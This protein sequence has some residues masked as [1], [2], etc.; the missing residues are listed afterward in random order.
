MGIDIFLQETFLT[1]DS[2][3]LL[4]YVDE[5]Y[6]SVGVGAVCPENGKGRPKGGLACLFKK[7]IQLDVDIILSN[8]DFMMTDITI[9][10]IKI[11][12]LNCYVRSNLG[13]PESHNQYL[14]NLYQMES[15]IEQHNNDNFITVGDF[16]ADPFYGRTWYDMKNF[17]DRNNLTC[18]DKELLPSD[19][20]TYIGFADSYCKWLDH[21]IGKI[22]EKIKFNY[23]KIA[24]D[25]I[26]S[27]H[28]PVIASIKID[29]NIKYNFKSSE[30][31]DKNLINWNTIPKLS[32]KKISEDAAKI[33]GTYRDWDVFKCSTDKCSSLK[34]F[35]S[36]VLMYE[37]MTK[38]VEYCSN[39]YKKKLINV[40]I[41][42]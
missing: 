9:S 15:M 23:I 12:F 8:D 29:T 27:D 42:N 26:G 24:H 38:P 39:D 41:L 21:I 16:N 28:F 13:D 10:D 20:F 31:D 25:C 19:S 30:N 6:Y 1:L 11:T 5:N 7:E 36:I 32:L 37:Y 14:N 3:T 34:C 33:V 2:L 17:I 18:F 40:N 22:S 4:Q 35:D